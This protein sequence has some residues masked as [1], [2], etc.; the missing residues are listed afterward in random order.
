[1]EERFG[2]SFVIYDRDFVSQVRRERG[3]AVNPWKTHTRFILSHALVRDE[4]YAAPLRALGEFS[5]GSLRSWMKLTTSR[6]PAGPLC[7]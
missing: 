4:L 2:L 5:G 1:M 3:Y 7:D 6:P